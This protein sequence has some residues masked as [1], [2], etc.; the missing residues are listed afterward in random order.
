MIF[1]SCYVILVIYSYYIFVEVSILN[2]LL[3]LFFKRRNI[4]SPYDYLKKI[5][6]FDHANLKDVDLLAVKLHDIYTGGKHI[7]ILPD[8]DTDGIMSG[9][10]GFAGL[11][12]MGFNVSLFIPNPADGYEFTDATIKRLISEYPDVSAIITCDVGVSCI[13][14][15]AY[16][17]SQNID[18]LVTDHHKQ[19]VSAAKNNKAS[20]IVNPMRLDETYSHPKICGAYV[21]YQ[22]LLY[23][24]QK[25]CSVLIQ[26]QVQRLCVFAGIGTISDSMPVLY[27]NR[28][29]LRDAIDVCRF[30]YFYGSDFIFDVMDGCDAYRKAFYGLYLVISYLFNEGKIRDERDIDEVLFGYY[31]A[32]MFNAP[33]RLNADMAIPFSVFFGND[34]AKSVE[35][36]YTLNMMRKQLVEDKFAS[37]FS[38]PQPYAPY[39]Y[40]SD[41]DEGVLGLLATKVMKTTGLPT[42]VLRPKADGSYKGSGR[43]PSWYDC[44]T[45]LSS[46]GF[47]AAGHEQAFGVGV[48]DAQELDDLFLFIEADVKVI[49][50]QLGSIDVQDESTA[51]IVISTLGD[52][53]VGI[54]ISAFREFMHDLC[55]FKPFG[56]DFAEPVLEFRFRFTD[57]EPVVMGHEKNHLKWRL[58]HGFEVLCFN[59]AYLLPTFDVN[60]VIRVVGSLGSSVYN[61]VLTTNFRGD[62]I[63]QGSLSK[64]DGSENE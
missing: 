33:K 59:Q 38:V 50:D 29:L 44:L 9:V 55:Y 37:I 43:A 24:A 25:Y 64:E 48:N 46:A 32:P 61:D 2:K 36:L 51:D 4:D 5:N 15:I 54:D 22:C 10:V 20:V 53:D 49:V 35:M 7:V 34:Q 42:I 47:Y 26:E 13:S 40:L 21:F 17:V 3:E 39:V 30:I 12:V 14:G 60:D 18:V 6:V 56:V 52:G 19:S 1:L 11:S 62:I 63:S 27:E 16:A 57:A 31:V 41:A 58:P 23:Y 8:F 28:K 45:R